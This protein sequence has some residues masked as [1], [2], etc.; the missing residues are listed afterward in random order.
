[1]I[2]SEDYLKLK[3][4]DSDY[5]DVFNRYLSNSN[6]LVIFTFGDKP[7]WFGRSNLNKLETLKVNVV[8]TAGAGDAFRAGIA[9]GLLNNFSD[10]FNVKFASAVSAASIQ[11]YPGVINFPGLEKVNKILESQNLTLNN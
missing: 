2:V 7:I 1:M 9:Y 3:Y 6:G 5:R 4:S 8:D 10:D 11:T